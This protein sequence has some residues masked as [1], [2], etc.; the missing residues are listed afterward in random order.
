MAT[1]TESARTTLNGKGFPL[2]SAG[3]IRTAIFGTL[4]LFFGW[5]A[6]SIMDLKEIVIRLEEG[7]K[8]IELL[9]TGK[10]Q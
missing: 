1:K 2:P 6:L 5:M 7:Q 10:D 9:L 4:A 8:R 3:V